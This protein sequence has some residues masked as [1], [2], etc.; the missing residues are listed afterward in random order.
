MIELR[1]VQKTFNDSNH[2]LRGINLRIETGET[3]AIIGESGCG[4]S[5]LLKHIMGLMTPDSGSVLVDGKDINKLDERDLYAL[6][7]RF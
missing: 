3:M 1:D 2:V 5:V 7:R 4:K 6:R